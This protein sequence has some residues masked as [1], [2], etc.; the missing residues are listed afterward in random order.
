MTFS[1]CWKSCA[2][3]T[4]VGFFRHVKTVRFQ[5]RTALLMNLF[6]ASSPLSTL[7]TVGGKDE[8]KSGSFHEA[9]T[10]LWA[11]TQ[12]VHTEQMYCWFPFLAEDRICP[13]AIL[14][15]VKIQSFS[16]CNMYYSVKWNLQFSLRLSQST[17]G[18]GEKVGC[19][20]RSGL[21]V[22]F[23]GCSWCACVPHL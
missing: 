13:R 17:C 9:S 2:G 8:H 1:C 16:K 22:W 6:L 11:K 3:P 20:L 21:A 5:P 12:T 23:P 10:C 4:A 18:V 14:G 7:K 15:H 19:S